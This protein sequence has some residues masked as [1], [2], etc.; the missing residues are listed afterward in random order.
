MAWSKPES[1]DEAEAA[2]PWAVGGGDCFEEEGGG[3]GGPAWAVKDMGTACCWRGRGGVGGPALPW[4]GCGVGNIWDSG[5]GGG[6]YDALSFAGCS[7]VGFWVYL[8]RGC[9]GAGGG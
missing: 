4:T 7:V 8:E 1:N 3:A 9:G 5:V 6:R 2:L